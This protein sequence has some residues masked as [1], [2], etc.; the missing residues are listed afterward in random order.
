MAASSKW[1][2]EW[3]KFKTNKLSFNVD[4]EERTT[5]YKSSG[6]I[7]SIDSL[8]KIFLNTPDKGMT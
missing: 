3:I 5:Q 7:A 6:N 1:F 4:A 2:E 8:E